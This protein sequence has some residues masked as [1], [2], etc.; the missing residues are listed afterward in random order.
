MCA[1]YAALL[2]AHLGELNYASRSSLILTFVCVKS[3][4]SQISSVVKSAQFLISVNC[5]FSASLRLV[6]LAGYYTN[7]N[8]NFSSKRDIP[9]R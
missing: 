7:L 9:R 3:T 4:F 2:G 6:Q 8:T 5:L 1:L